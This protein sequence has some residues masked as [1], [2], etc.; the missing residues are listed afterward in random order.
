[1][2]EEDYREYK[3]LRIWWSGKV[4]RH[5]K[6]KGW[7][8]VKNTG[9]DKNGYNQVRVNGKLWFRHRL[10]M[11]AYKP[12]FDINNNKLVID[13]IDENRLN[14]SMDNLRVTNKSG[15]A[16]N[17][18]SVKGYTWHK[19]VK[20]WQPQ[21]MANGKRKYLGLCDTEEAARA[22]YLAAKAKY[23]VIEEIC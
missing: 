17:V 9:N 12:D 16:Y 3:G 10:V 13:H 23:H 21:I 8:V 5:F 15:N 6:S 14:N 22:A 2:E 7:V 4:M 20:K 19:G 11:A 18:S 1:M